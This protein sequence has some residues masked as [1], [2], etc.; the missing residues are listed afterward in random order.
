MDYEQVM[1]EQGSSKRSIVKIQNE[2]GIENETLALKAIKQMQEKY[3]L[4]HHKPG[5][6]EETKQYEYQPGVLFKNKNYVDILP[7][8][9]KSVDF[10]DGK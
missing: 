2:K 4:E 7:S 10:T 9:I 6:N 5:E 1:H 3:P 8:F